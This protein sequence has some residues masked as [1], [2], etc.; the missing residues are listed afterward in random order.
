MRSV[1]ALQARTGE[2]SGPGLFRAV[3]QS[4]E[5]T[6]RSGAAHHHFCVQLMAAL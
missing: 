4:Y 2:G 5:M 3:S 6:T 1:V